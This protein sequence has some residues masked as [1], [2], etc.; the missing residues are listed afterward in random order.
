MAVVRSAGC[1][2]WCAVFMVSASLCAAPRAASALIA[3]GPPAPAADSSQHDARFDVY[4][5]RVLGNSKLEER[6]VDQVL[7][8]FLGPQRTLKDV[9]AARVALET[10]YHQR[11]YGTVF[12]DIPEQSVEG[13]LV[14]LRVS[15]GTLGRVTIMG[16]RYYS[17][18]QILAAL[19]EARVGE[20]PQLPEL[21]AE[22]NALNAQSRDRQITPII[23]AGARAGT[24]D[25]NLKVDDHLPL[26]ASV[27]LN[28]QYTVDTEP[29][30]LI[31]GLSYD[32]L[33]GRLDSISGQYQTSPQDTHQVQV[34]AGSY[35]THISDS[36]THLT[37]YYYHS[38]SSVAT[39]ASGSGSLTVLGK[40]GVA[41]ARLILPLA[42]TENAVQ[43]VTFGADYKD[44]DENINSLTN[45][46]AQGGTSSNTQLDT[47]IKYVNFSAGY[48]GGWRNSGLP[49]TF[50]ATVNLGV[51][52][53]KNDPAEFEDKR[54]LAPANYIYLRS[55][56]T[57][58][59]P[60][61]KKLTVHLGYSGQYAVDPIISN[62]QFSI[63]GIDGVRGYLEAEAL[64]D[65]AIK[66]T[67]QLVPAPLLLLDGRISAGTYVFFDYGL[68]GTIDA[69]PGEVASTK[70]S[71]FG[72]GL[73]LAAFGH[74]NAGVIWVDP[75]D[76][77]IQTQHGKSRVLFSAR[78]SW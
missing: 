69:L 75:L 18:R 7:Y 21:Q 25:L 67:V 24:V 29:L 78:S 19:P 42:A 20:T 55:T 58:D 11:G 57:V 53:V 74:V 71:S 73:D 10:L 40:G 31:A 52:G 6:D 9:E 33:F 60:V 63:A 70:F 2:T 76:D 72:L 27:E 61:Y 44:F 16:T 30:R 13:G 62:E 68:A 47:P 22:V 50:S 59:W 17:N 23:K 64:G 3:A 14:R 65:R 45:T 54:F 32:N 8:P 12:V 56:G 46:P 49:T 48:S 43:T 36:A 1:A 38:N 5:L 34:W 39:L 15:E 51:R 77:G 28:N 26:H 37:L 41:G 66:G 4:E 35:T